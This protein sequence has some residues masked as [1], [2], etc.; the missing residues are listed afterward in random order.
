MKR[1]H[2]CETIGEQWMNN[3]ELATTSERDFIF[4]VDHCTLVLD[5]QMKGTPQR[6]IRSNKT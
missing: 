2:K 5:S 6:K 4:F 3:R 1:N